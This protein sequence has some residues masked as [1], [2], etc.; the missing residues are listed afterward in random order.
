[1]ITAHFFILCL[2]NKKK[3]LI[4]FICVTKHH[5]LFHKR[6][7]SLVAKSAD[8]FVYAQI[9]MSSK[10]FGLLDES[11]TG[12]IGPSSDPTKNTSSLCTTKS[13]F[14]MRNSG[15]NSINSPMMVC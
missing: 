14:E 9:M 10:L 15:G 13:V 2:C 5:S 1:M 12:T 4:V 8:D 7:C 6:I 3:Y 11:T